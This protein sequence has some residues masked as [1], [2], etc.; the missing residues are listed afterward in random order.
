[1]HAF[2][3]PNW[4]SP[5]SGAKAAVS[6]DDAPDLKATQ[7]CARATV[8]PTVYSAATAKSQA[9]SVAVN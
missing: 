4:R 9:S 2:G 6:A 7:L 8:H 1:M 5:M 3:D